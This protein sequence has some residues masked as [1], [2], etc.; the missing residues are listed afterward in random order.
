MR[1]PGRPRSAAGSGRRAAGWG[2]T[3][4]LATAVLAGCA[5]RQARPI[6]ASQPHDT[7]MNCQQLRSELLATRSMIG[8]YGVDHAQQSDRNRQ[9]LVG[10]VFMPVALMNMDTGT[11]S[12]REAAAY[13]ARA[14][15][16]E[17]LG[18]T[19][20]CSND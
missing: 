11:A 12:E 10:A 9:A 8:K 1:Y 3:V 17:T 6:E 16:L 19:K 18:K 2:L 4:A 14:T 20:G 13:G 5:Q 15:H 7:L